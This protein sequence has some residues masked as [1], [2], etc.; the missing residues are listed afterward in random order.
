MIRGGSTWQ[1]SAAVVLV[2][3]L[4]LSLWALPEIRE[5]THREASWQ[6]LDAPGR[7]SDPNTVEGESGLIVT[8][9]VLG[10][11]TKAPEG[12]GARYAIAA[13]T[14]VKIVYRATGKGVPALDASLAGTV[15]VE[16]TW[17]AAHLGSNIVGTG[18]SF[19]SGW[20]FPEPGCWQMTVQRG[21]QEV[22]TPVLVVP[23]PF[24]ENRR[25]VL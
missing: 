10:P 12:A 6:C 24:M 11:L 19:G 13:D 22:K 1:L 21:D 2:P 4:S 16:P 8:S 9:V 5:K 3:L 23:R 17:E 25:S 14:E 7:V 20:V 18:D 15:H